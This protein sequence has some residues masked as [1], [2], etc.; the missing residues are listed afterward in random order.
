MEHLILKTLKFDLSSPT[1]FNFLERY[2]AAANASSDDSRLGSL[3][4][5]CGNSHYECN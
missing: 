3:A 4:K 2:L 1:A 5:V